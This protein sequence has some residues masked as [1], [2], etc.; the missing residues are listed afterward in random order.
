MTWWQIALI[1]YGAIGFLFGLLMAI[2]STE[3]QSIAVKVFVVLCGLV[4]GGFVVIIG[5]LEWLLQK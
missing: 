5:G 2:F 1:A 3:G 4:I